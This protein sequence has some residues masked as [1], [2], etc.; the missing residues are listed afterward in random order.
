MRKRPLNVAFSVLILMALAL[1]TLGDEAAPPR[2]PWKATDPN[3]E[4]VVR[5][6]VE[7]CAAYPVTEVGAPER[8]VADITPQTA[9]DLT[10][11]TKRPTS[12]N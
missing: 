7:G 9:V 6:V 12:D 11:E 1:P 2:T 5:W 8:S 10:A 3:S 4:K